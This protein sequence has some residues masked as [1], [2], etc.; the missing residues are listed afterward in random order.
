MMTKDTA[1]LQ[2][3]DKLKA[4]A[5]IS[6]KLNTIL[7]LEPLLQT[8]IDIAADLL[9][10]EA[11]S[12][13]LYDDEK[14][15]LFFAAATGAHSSELEHIDV[16]L[17]RSLAGAIFRTQKSVFVNDVSKDP[18]HFRRVERMTNYHVRSLL[19]VPMSLN[20]RI[21]GVLEAINK[22]KA[23]FSSRDV[24][25]LSIVASQAAV[26]INNA[27]IVDELQE[28]N[29][30]LRR[31]DQLKNDFLAVVSHELRTPL[32]LILGYS[33]FLREEVDSELVEYADKIVK[34][35]RQMTLLVEDMTDMKVIH[36]G[37][38][39]ISLQ[40][41]PIQVVLKNAYQNVAPLAKAKKIPVIFK[42]PSEKVWV[43]AD[44]SLEKVFINILDNAIRFSEPSG[45][46]VVRVTKNEK[47]VGVAIKDD[48]AG[49]PP[50]SLERIFDQFYQV[51]DHLTREH[52]GL[53][54]GLSI[55]RGLVELHGGKI[56]AESP[57]PGKGSTFKVILPLGT[58]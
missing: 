48:G 31:A 17:D 4:L 1:E 54:L 2:Q 46:I 13:L 28:V 19:G 57:G 5:E 47:Q 7:D 50:N 20:D 32:G 52:G 16:P 33:T 12:I 42:V 6:L 49:I 27:R 29:R 43:D 3:F 53:G 45:E 55:A 37:S 36:R 18:R 24:Q 9:D 23:N 38:V 10:C 25:L 14:E 30:E 44:T 39:D 40:P 35:V 21:I 22:R 41:T 58:P 15:C 56:W 26:A 11:G 34:A 51:E 8:I